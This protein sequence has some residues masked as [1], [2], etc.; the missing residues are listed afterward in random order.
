MLTGFLVSQ[1]AVLVQC[2]AIPPFCKLLDVKDT[3]VRCLH[4]LYLCTP[5]VLSVKW[6]LCFKPANIGYSLSFA[7][8][9][10]QIVLDG[11]NNILK[12][13]CH[14]YKVEK[15]IIS[16]MILLCCAAFSLSALAPAPCP[17]ALALALLPVMITHTPDN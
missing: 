17:L 6:R 2:G 14:F 13:R 1:V 3:Q 12:V 5:T 4:Y 7:V 10:V 15:F 11:L 16:C 9:V 8:K